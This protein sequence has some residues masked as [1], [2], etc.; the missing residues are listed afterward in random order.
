MTTRHPS[1]AQ[2][3]Q[4]RATL[5]AG[6]LEQRMDHNARRVN[7]KARRLAALA[8]SIPA[9]LMDAEDRVRSEM[10]TAQAHALLERN[11]KRQERTTRQLHA[12]LQRAA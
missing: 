5:A 7:R 11:A 1:R 2:R 10:L 8:T 12:F 4:H 9:W 3:R 6:T